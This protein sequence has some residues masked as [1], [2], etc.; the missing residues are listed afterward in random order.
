MEIITDIEKLGAETMAATIGSFD[1]VHRGH[2]AMIEEALSLSSVRGLPLT[3]ITFA[4][5]P[6][7]LFSGWESPF[8]LCSTEEK[9]ALLAQA[10]VHRCL[11]LDFD[12]KMAA[13][14]AREFMRDILRDKL[15]V[16]FLAVGYDHRFGRPLAGET[17]ADY[18]LYGKEM[19]IEV[20]LMSCFA[21][22]GEKISS[23]KVRGALAA[24]D[25]MAAAQLLGRNYSIAG[26]VEHG[27]ALGR[28]IGFPTANI[29]LAESLQLLP[30]DGVY[31]CIF[32]V[33][34]KEYQGV[35]N[36]GCKPTVGSAVRTIEV[37]AIG[38]DSDIYGEAVKVEFVRRL[39][40]ERRFA[41]IDDLRGQIEAD[42]RRVVDGL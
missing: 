39:R 4:K 27:A 24:G 11:L 17:A 20:A 36:I 13:L 40:G 1:G 42:V 30:L 3:V 26:T 7:L 9:L 34:G 23:S 14:T 22:G 41:D 2:V 37:Y 15:G 32:H 38:L 6:R 8:L 19:G 31:E 25:V 12:K 28:R 21:P 33:S 29:A 16:E 10:G 35:M 5:H 18:A